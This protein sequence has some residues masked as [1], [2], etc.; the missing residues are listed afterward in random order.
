MR[1][2]R[3]A[4]IAV[5]IVAVLIVG[6]YFLRGYLPWFGEGSRGKAAV[7]AP[8]R[9]I[10]AAA[11]E[12]KAVPVQVEAVGT[13]EPI[14]TVAIR[15]RVDGHVTDIRVKPGDLVQAGQVMF[16]LDQR[17]F[18]AAVDQAQAAVGRDQAAYLNA[19]EE[20]T[21]Q[22]QL[23]AKQL[24]TQQALDSAKA[25]LEVTRQA[26]EVSKAAVDAAK[27]NL[28][29]ATIRAPI[30]GRIG[31]PNIDIGT[32]V[33]SSDAAAIVTINQ[34]HPIYATFS[35]AQRYLSEIRE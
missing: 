24:T 35:V 16:V 9:L 14:R 33:R 12:E 11:V 27:L 28:E 10:R 31:K 13:V 7:V 20:A 32:I 17:P 22:D 30:P 25:A 4:F 18:R 15:S 34:T 23:M 1:L 5:G 8:P 6:G 2:P 26:V 19:Q 29:F 3:W 21:R